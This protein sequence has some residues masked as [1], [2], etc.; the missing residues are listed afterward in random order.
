M[1]TRK[2]TAAKAAPAAPETPATVVTRFLQAMAEQDHGTVA[3]L[4]APDVQYTNVSLPTITGG[5]RVAKVLRT[6]L[7]PGVAFEV[8]THSIAANG[9]T[10]L[11]ERTDAL[12]LGPLHLQFWVCGTFRVENGRITLWRDYFDWV[13]MGKAAVR[14]VLGIAVPKLRPTLPVALGR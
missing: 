2:K 13:D 1:T 10:V 8:Q 4:L 6:A 11:T 14:G 12:K 5:E 7:R 9:D 3:A